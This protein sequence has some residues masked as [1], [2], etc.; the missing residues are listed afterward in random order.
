M[1]AQCDSHDALIA[2]FLGSR[3]LGRRYLRYAELEALG[4]VDCRDSLNNWMRAGGFP[5]SIK[6]PSRYG[7]TLVWDAVEVAQHIAQR[8]AERDLIPENDEGALS[9]ERPSDS[10]T[11]PATGR[12]ED[13]HVSTRAARPDARP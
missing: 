8:C 10:E 11:G 2:R 3:Y 13:N 6:I 12:N 4:I 7:K 5:R 9:R 1:D